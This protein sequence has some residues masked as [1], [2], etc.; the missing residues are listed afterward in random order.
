MSAP[1]PATQPPCACVGN[2]EVDDTAEYVYWQQLSDTY[3]HIMSGVCVYVCMYVCM[4]VRTY[5]RTYVCMYVCMYVC[6]CVYIYIYV[7]THIPESTMTITKSRP[8]KAVCGLGC[9][10]MTYLVACARGALPECLG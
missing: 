1:W 9:C 3:S 10:A 2:R 7:Y 5:V 4:Y 6:V 8:H